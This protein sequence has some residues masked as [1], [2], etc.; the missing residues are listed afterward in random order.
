MHLGCKEQKAPP[1]DTGSNGGA[2]VLLRL[3]CLRNL[4]D[5]GQT[6]A[7]AG[8]FPEPEVISSA[9]GLSMLSEALPDA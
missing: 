5:R 8:F 3:N 4:N 6:F 7:V 2:I 1:C 9:Q